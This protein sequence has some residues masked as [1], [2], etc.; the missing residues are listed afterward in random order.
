MCAF[1]A[2][3]R[4][5]FA[6]RLSGK[7]KST[8]MFGIILWAILIILIVIASCPGFLTVFFCVA[9]PVGVGVYLLASWI[10]A[11]LRRW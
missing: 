7:L 11:K 8:S 6:H 1:F 2:P 5:N 4:L 9:L 3:T 10:Q